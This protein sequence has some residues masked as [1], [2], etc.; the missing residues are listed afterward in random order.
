M[1]P[2]SFGMNTNGRFPWIERKFNWHFKVPV[3]FNDLTERDILF[4]AS[5]YPWQLD[6]GFYKRIIHHLCNFPKRKIFG[7]FGYIF[8][9]TEPEAVY[10]LYTNNFNPDPEKWLFNW[11]LKE[12]EGYKSIISHFK[13]N[14]T[15][16]VSHTPGLRNITIEEFAEAEQFL[17]MMIKNQNLDP[18]ENLCAVLF[19]PEFEVFQ[20]DDCYKR[21]IAFEQLNREL[22]IAVYLQY[23]AQRL[24]MINHNRKMFRKLN[25]ESMA[26]KTDTW[27]DI[28]NDLS[29]HFTDVSK[30]KKS[31]AWEVF[32]WIPHVNK[33][34]KQMEEK[35]EAARLKSQKHNTK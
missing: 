14:G 24:Y 34:G 28:I 29:N 19:K 32:E 13:L 11:L 18:L 22:K 9:R 21:A 4:L 33:R 17:D 2:C 3:E 25:P 1:I 10:Q 31:L 23:R 26:K 15:N 6:E 20:V 7:L 12:P 35:L 5:E 27:K 16:Y 8:L 30:V